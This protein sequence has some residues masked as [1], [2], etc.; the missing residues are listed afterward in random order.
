MLPSIGCT[1]RLSFPTER[2][3]FLGVVIGEGSKDD[4]RF[5]ALPEPCSGPLAR[6]D[7]SERFAPQSRLPANG[8]HEW[9]LDFE[10]VTGEPREIESLA[11]NKVAN[12][13]PESR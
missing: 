4:P 8:T 13:E 12:S 1:L 9:Y 5:F 2:I 11:K 7:L 3:P 10:A 6:L